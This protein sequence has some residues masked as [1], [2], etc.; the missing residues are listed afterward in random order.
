MAAAQRAA[1]CVDSAEVQAIR[2]AL[3]QYPGL[4][5]RNGEPIDVASIR[6]HAEYL[7]HA[8]LA[9]HF[10]TVAQ[11]VPKLMADAQRAALLARRN[12]R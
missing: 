6:S 11:H 2:A 9:S 3:D 7:D 12:S 8:W 1:T 4:A 5:A 10:T